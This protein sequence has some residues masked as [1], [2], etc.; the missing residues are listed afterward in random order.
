MIY[1]SGRYPVPVVPGPAPARPDWASRPASYLPVHVRKNSSSIAGVEDKWGAGMATVITLL[2]C[3]L[4]AD[5]VV[6]AVWL[7]H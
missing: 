3:C 5:A 2:A 6:V 7:L 4:A 1:Y